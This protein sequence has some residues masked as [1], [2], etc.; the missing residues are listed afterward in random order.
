VG[1]GREHRKLSGDTETAPAGAATA[2]A[3]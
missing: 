2:T 3:G 1:I